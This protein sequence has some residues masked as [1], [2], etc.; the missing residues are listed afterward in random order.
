M[1]A[2]RLRADTKLVKFINNK[3]NMFF[4]SRITRLCLYFILRGSLLQESEIDCSNQTKASI[5]ML[6]QSHLSS[7]IILLIIK[8]LFCNLCSVGQRKHLMENSGWLQGFNHKSMK[9]NRIERATDAK[10]EPSDNGRKHLRAQLARDLVID[11]KNAGANML[12]L[13]EAEQTLNG[14]L[15]PTSDLCQGSILGKNL[16]CMNL[17][18]NN[19]SS[20]AP[21]LLTCQRNH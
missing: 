1:H 7:T 14:S 20:N 5:L 8:S 21:N 11:S 19:K 4:S 9:T 12:H 6:K 17:I 13:Y 15:Y 18:Y 2:K 10:D 16:L 3:L